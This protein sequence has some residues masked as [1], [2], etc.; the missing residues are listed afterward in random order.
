MTDNQ[1]ATKAP[2]NAFRLDPLKGDAFSWFWGILWRFRSFYF[3]SMLAT[4]IANVL[5]LASIFF[6]MNVYNRIV[7]N[8][9]YASLWALAIGTMLAI[10]FEFL[11]RWLKARLVDLGGKKADLAINATLL[12]EIMAI[13]LEHRPASI[14]IFASS[15]RDFDSLRDFFSSA[16]LVL[17]AD[18]PFT[19]MFL[20][21]IWLVGGPIVW[22]PLLTICILV[23]VGLL[24]QPALT[25]A[26]R[27]NMR[28]AG[29]RQS[30]LVEALL[31]LEVL[32]AHNEK[33][34]LQQR[35]DIANL[36]SAESY[37]KTR[38]ITNFMT[39]FTMMLQQLTT[40]GVL[41]CGVYLIH[42]NSLT[43]GALIAVVMLSGRA[44][45]P[46]ANVMSLASRYQQA[47]S[48]LET[49]DGLMRRPRDEDSTIRYIS[50]ENFEGKLEA[51]DI[52]FTYPY[53]QTLPAI[54][55]VSININ[56]G[57]R[58][59]LLGGIGC[60]KSTLL[61]LMSGLYLPL[62]GSVRIDGVDLRQINPET[63]RSRIGY[64]GQDPQLFMGTLRA[65]LILSSQNI[66]DSKIL[67]VLKELGIYEFVAAH[68]RGL[69]M[70]LTEAGGGLSGGQRQLLGLA[71]LM[72][73]DPVYVF[74]DEPTSHMDPQTEAMVIALMQ[75]W[76]KS[77]TVLISTHRY[78]LLEWVSRV[79]VID[80]GKAVSDTSKED[81]LKKIF[82]NVS[83]TDRPAH[84]STIEKNQ[85]NKP[86]VNYRIQW[87]S[88]KK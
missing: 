88:V 53:A 18:L 43:L 69:D 45:A 63:L 56:P 7:P 84:S 58:L 10:I 44:I 29:D 8:Y 31:N 50:P 83:V 17:V 15:M 38:S 6:T 66:S 71:R 19:L 40:V 13:R 21:L 3:E 22:I 67:D 68:P 82:K 78:Q 32:K 62:S 39:G 14:G 37:K 85:K 26:T 65:N 72:L 5:T 60:G 12:R 64:L 57:E 61:R 25:R 2:S 24:V 80:H 48:A 51:L 54:Q 34:Y 86:H 36:A 16:S 9:A 23:F 81:L 20:V 42:A 79:V 75:K 52:S 33:N 55:N 70:Q 1:N 4:V 35:W 30:V 11:M 77:K 47:A 73:R 74:M 49:L 46:L 76:L 41:V 28:E 59:A 27:L 87:G